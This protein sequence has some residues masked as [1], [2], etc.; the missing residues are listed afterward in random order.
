MKK[1]LLRLTRLLF[2]LVLL[3]TA[4]GKLL[5]NRGFAD[6]IANYQLIPSELGLYVGLAVSLFEL[7][8]G[9]A[10][11]IEK[12][13][14][15]CA[16]LVVL[17]QAGYLLLACVT[18]FRGIRLQNCGCFGVFWGRPLTFYTVLEDF[19]LLLIAILFYQLT[20]DRR[21]KK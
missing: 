18:I 6:I 5:D 14:R 8:L 20:L 13:L 17:L 3:T 2:I 4:I 11:A 1:T 7:F 21:E 19:I 16:G 10:I 12:R 9:L 15:V